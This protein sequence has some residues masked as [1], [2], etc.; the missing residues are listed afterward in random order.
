MCP[1]DFLSV[2]DDEKLRDKVDDALNVYNEYLKS[3][4]RQPGEIGSSEAAQPDEPAN[5]ESEEAAPAE[6]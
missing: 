3:A 1:A 4:P 6:S 2:D 5:H